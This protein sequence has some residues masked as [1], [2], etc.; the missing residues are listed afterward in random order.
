ME[1]TMI[2]IILILLLLFSLFFEKNL[3][4]PLSVF[5]IIWITILFLSNMKLYNMLPFSTRPYWIVLIGC[6]GYL[7]GY[8]FGKYALSK[9]KKN[10]EKQIENKYIFN[11]KIIKILNIVLL[12]FYLAAA[13]RVYI[14]MR[15]YGMDYSSMRTLYV[16]GTKEQQIEMIFGSSMLKGL[17]LLFFKPMLFSMLS[18][19]IARVFTNM[20]IDKQSIITIITLVLSVFV[21][22]SRIVLVQIAFCTLI[23][24]LTMGIK[25]SKEEKLKIKKIIKRYVLPGFIVL[26]ALFIF[27]SSARQSNRINALSFNE[28]LYAYL[29][30]PMPIMDYWI[31]YVDNNQIQTYGILYIRGAL[32]VVDTFTNKLGFHIPGY[33]ESTEIVNSTQNFLPIFPN[34]KYNAFTTLFYYFYV[35]W[36]EVGVFICSAIYGILMAIAYYKTRSNKKN[37]L[38]IV[39]YIMLLQGLLKC[40]VRWEF[41]QMSYFISFIFIFVLILKRKEN[42]YEK[43]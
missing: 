17:E 40:F 34:N 8:V 14:S 32:S 6:F 16:N 41:V 7:C 3:Y 9:R 19:S 37:L 42:N 31:D 4:N 43:E 36:R 28:E 10:A 39:M 1:I 11:E 35:D 21:N 24:Y 2:L 27:I 13:L 26:L 30:I 29:S 22:F 12:L 38:V 18:I 15:K 5:L 23:T 20:K 25:F 33:L